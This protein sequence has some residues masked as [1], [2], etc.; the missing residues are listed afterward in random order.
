LTRLNA[1]GLGNLGGHLAQSQQVRP[2][3]SCN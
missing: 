3:A 1:L 2:R